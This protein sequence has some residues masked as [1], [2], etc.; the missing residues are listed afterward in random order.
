MVR[1]DFE[2]R[3]MVSLGDGFAMYAVSIPEFRIKGQVAERVAKSPP[4][5]MEH[6]LNISHQHN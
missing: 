4:L 5:E 6:C 1:E 3:D 2:A